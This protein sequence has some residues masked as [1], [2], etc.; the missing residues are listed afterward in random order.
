MFASLRDYLV[1]KGIS[2]QL[3]VRVQRNAHHSLQESRHNC[4]ER[5]V[6]LLHIISEPLRM[7]IHFE[8]YAP[9]LRKHPLF[10][11]MLENEGSSVTIRKVSHSAVNT[12]I[13]STGDVLFTDGEV[14]DPA[15]MYFVTKGDIRYKHL[16]NGT[17]YLSV[18]DWIAEPVLWLQ[19]THRGNLKAWSECELLALDANAFRASAQQARNQHTNLGRYAIE[20]GKLISQDILTDV[21]EEDIAIETVTKVFHEEELDGSLEKSASGTGHILFNMLGKRGSFLTHWAPVRSSNRGS[22]RV[23]NRDSDRGGSREAGVVPSKPTWL[24]SKTS[25]HLAAGGSKHSLQ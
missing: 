22:N 2:R 24:R 6:E 5:D 1:D 4:P 7:E 23:S 8:L 15:E 20:F 17:T 18:G 10:A 12:T 21:D 3:T 14:K 25:P 19:W 9:I 13:L 11:Y 16:N